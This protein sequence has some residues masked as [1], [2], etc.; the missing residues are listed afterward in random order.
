MPCEADTD[1]Q[2]HE[3]CRATEHV[4]LESHGHGL[5][6]RQCVA[7]ALPAAQCGG[8]TLPWLFEKC[9]PGLTCVP[10]DLAM[11]DSPGTCQA[12]D[13]CIDFSWATCTDD[14]D[15]PDPNG[16]RCSAFRD[17]CVPSQCRCD[18]TCTND[19]I[20]NVGVCES[21]SAGCVVWPGCAAA[22]PPIDL[23]VRL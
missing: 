22:C 13:P 3:W 4:A 20:T 16:E 6:R 5:V 17:G 7:F 14:A 18:G 9:A 19:C 11:V 10:D 2:P 8:Y 12:G 1:C 23:P 15:C 21:L